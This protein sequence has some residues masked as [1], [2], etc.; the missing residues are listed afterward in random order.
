VVR[1]DV[2]VTFRFYVQVE[3]AVPAERIEHVVKEADAGADTCAP[4][5]VEHDRH[6]HTRLL[7]LAPDLSDPAGR[8]YVERL[9][10]VACCLLPVA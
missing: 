1:V 6:A 7:R 2:Q 9:L 5:A 8:R 3:A 4:C 10:P